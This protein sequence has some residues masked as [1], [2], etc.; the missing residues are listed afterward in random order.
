MSSC[1]SVKARSHGTMC[2]FA[3]AIFLYFS[4]RFKGVCLHSAMSVDAICYVY[5]NWVHIA[6][7]GI[8]HRNRTEWV[9]NLI[10]CDVAH[11]SVSDAH[12]IAPYEHPD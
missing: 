12:E 2:L 1:P 7:T 11:T 10:V 8:T 5:V 3:T 4:V 9:W 6:F